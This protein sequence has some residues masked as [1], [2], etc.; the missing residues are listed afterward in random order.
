M[1]FLALDTSSEHTCAVATRS[2]KIIFEIKYGGKYGASKL[3][4][5]MQQALTEQAFELADFDAFVVG[6]G[7]GSFTGLRIAFSF[8][9]GLSLVS[10]VG[11][12]SLDSFSAIAYRLTKR[13]NCNIGVFSDARRGLVYG[14][15]FKPARGK[16]VEVEKKIKLYK[17]DEFIAENQCLFATYNDYLLKKI[18]NIDNIKYCPQPVFPDARD[19][20]ELAETKFRKKQ[21]TELDNLQPLYI[22]PSDCQ[23]KK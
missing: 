20:I 8:I 17:L 5:Y 7:P 21:F 10:N 23:I 14:A 13:Y 12:I 6:A 9:K 19:L 15:V 18:K 16:A 11:V 4:S 3:A 2:N 22:H 1:N